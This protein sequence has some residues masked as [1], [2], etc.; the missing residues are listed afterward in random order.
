[1]SET[2]RAFVLVLTFVGFLA[3]YAG[4][5]TIAEKL[6]LTI[7]PLLMWLLWRKVIWHLRK[8]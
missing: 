6:F 2:E 8:R 1:M 7:S 4:E 3:T 5:S